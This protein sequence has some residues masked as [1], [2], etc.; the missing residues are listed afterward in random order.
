MENSQIPLL[1]IKKLGTINYA[2]IKSEVLI[3]DEKFLSK[4]EH[5]HLFHINRIEEYRNREFSPIPPHRKTVHDCMFLTNGYSLRTKGIDQYKFGENQFF[6]QPAL[7]IS[8]HEY[9]SEDAE[10]FYMHF[11]QEIFHTLSF[12]Y[13]KN[14]PF[15]DFFENPIITIPSEVQKTIINIFERIETIYSDFSKS[16]LDLVSWYLMAMMTE[17]KKFVTVEKSEKH[18]HAASIVKQYKNALTQHI[19]EK[20]TVKD[21]ADFLNITP[22]HLNKCVKSILQKT[23]QELL[24]EMLIVEAKFLLR[25]SDLSISE[26]SYNLCN[27]SPS[28]FIRFFK[29]QTGL[30]PKEFLSQ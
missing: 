9:I 8:S 7:Q 5:H 21:Y 28:N 15:L 2:E 4:S 26:I 10:G 23:A 27:Q 17:V 16:D 25:Y 1:D 13:L 30:T 3:P 14:F 11:S 18:N 20:Q 29:S 6:F 12:N 24:K 19:H 22:N